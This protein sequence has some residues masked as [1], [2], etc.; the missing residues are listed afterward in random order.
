MK[1][2]K[3]IVQIIAAVIIVGAIIY[4][5]VHKPV[6]ISGPVTDVEV[7]HVSLPQTRAD[8]QARLAVKN[9]LYQ[10]AKEIN[11]PTG[12]INSP[13]DG[14]SGTIAQNNTQ[15]SSQNGTQGVPFTIS[16]FAGKKV[17]LVDFWTYSCINCERTIP[18][19]NAWYKKYKD[20][21]LEIIGVHTPEFD[22]EKVYPNVAAAVKQYGIQYPVVLDSNMGTWNAYNNQYW[23]H[24]YLIDID[25][26]VVHDHI[27]EG[28]YDV[29]EKAIQ[30]ALDER[31]QVLGLSGS[32]TAT[33]T[34]PT[35]IVKPADV[36]S[37]DSNAVQ[38]PETYFGAARN[39]Y[40]ANG[41]RGLIG[42]QSLSI[43][44]AALQNP[45]PNSLY[46]EGD[47]NFQPQ[48]AESTSKTAKILYYY[49]AKNVYFVAA[50]STTANSAGG[51]SVSSGSVKNSVKITVKLDGV[52]Q[53]TMTIQAN[54]L[55][56]LIQGSDYAAHTLEIDVDGAGLD[57]FT[58]TFG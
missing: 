7:S 46:L 19:L 49:K 10:K 21:G 52:T 48:F 53:S 3:I 35:G 4:I 23:P 29:T 39:Q 6:S 43:S 41:N 24:E 37:M 12:F 56:P 38:S 51:T 17:V 54:K 44:G 1:K 13:N 5:E 8:D 27:G 22:F 11:N 18:Y 28:D 55:Y 45:Q 42:T 40:L 25:G 50:A 16:Q 31:S 32:T 47:W 9:R 33:V 2:N 26:Y 15:N 36:I 57:A 58:F 30:T 20:A 14:A 34:V